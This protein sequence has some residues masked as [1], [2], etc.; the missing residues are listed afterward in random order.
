M[1]LK[2]AHAILT[3][4]TRAR[5]AAI[6]RLTGDPEAHWMDVEDQVSAVTDNPEAAVA[7]I[8]A[9][10]AET[11]GT[12]GEIYNMLAGAQLENVRAPH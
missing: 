10:L 7:A 5:I 1:Y 9:A 2:E 11:W 8:S 12:Q 3:E 4:A 6:A